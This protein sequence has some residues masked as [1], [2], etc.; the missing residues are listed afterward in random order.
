MKKLVLAVIA[1]VALSVNVFAQGVQI[2]LDNLN[3]AGGRTA[4]A[5]G[6]FFNGNG[7]AVTSGT[8]NLTVLGGADAGSLQPVANLTGLNALFYSGVPG[9]FLDPQ[10]GTYNVPGV[11]NGGTATLRLLAWRGGAA[12]YS[13]AATTDQFY[14]WSGSAEVTG[15]S[16]TFT[17]ATGGG[18][19]PPGP[20]KSLDGM[21]AMVLQV[22][23]PSTMALAGLGAAAMLIFRR[24]K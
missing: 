3:G 8:I 6:L 19:T 11:A 7:T 9:V 12:A 24:R 5:N 18:G 21:P 22:P 14:A 1:V 13:A 20:P 23:E 2:T 17:Q 16:F 15:S 4:T 10:F